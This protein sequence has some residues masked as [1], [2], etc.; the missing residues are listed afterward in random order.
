I[1]TLKNL[2]PE[3]AVS[4]LTPYGK[5]PGGLIG[6]KGSPV[7]VIRDYSENVKRMMEILE[8]VDVA[9]PVDIETVVIPIKY[10]LA[11]E[12]ANVLSGLGAST[13]SGISGGAGSAGGFTSGGGLGTAGG[14]Q[15]GGIGQQ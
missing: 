4:I 14:F 10:A 15:G 12:I 7:L 9:L 6:V 2:T 1:V 11:G 8:R 5:L 13:G 3:D